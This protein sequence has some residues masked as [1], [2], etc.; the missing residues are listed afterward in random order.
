MW[1][2]CYSQQEI[3]EEVGYSQKAVSEF[4]DSIHLIQ[5]GTSAVLYKSDENALL[6]ET[7]DITEFDE[8]EKEDTNSLGTYNLD[9][10]LLIKANH[11]DETFK[12]PIY[13]IWKKQNKS[14]Q[15]DKNL[16]LSLSRS[17]I[18]APTM[19]AT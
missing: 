12:P 8:E 18:H 14:D 5:N 15:V 9:K 13:N 11:H 16:A 17:S 4:L 1:L 3:A 7:A 6:T 19:D 10:R 2:A